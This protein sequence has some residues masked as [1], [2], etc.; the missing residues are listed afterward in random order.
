MEAPGKDHSRN[1]ALMLL[2]GH[3]RGSHRWLGEEVE[4]VGGEDNSEEDANCLRRGAQAGVGNRR[5]R[6]W[7]QPARAVHLRG[8]GTELSST[9]RDQLSP[10]AEFPPKSTLLFPEI[11]PMSRDDGAATPLG[12]NQRSWKEKGPC[13]QFPAT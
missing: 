6:K 4:P 8:P 10:S 11:V 5:S 2:Q 7:K 9:K 3:I 1:R 12:C 13:C